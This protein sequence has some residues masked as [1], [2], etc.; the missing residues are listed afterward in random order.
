LNEAGFAVDIGIALAIPAEKTNNNNKAFV[1]FLPLSGVVRRRF[2]P[3]PYF[4]RKPKGD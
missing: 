1:I 2:Q 4:Y 3:I